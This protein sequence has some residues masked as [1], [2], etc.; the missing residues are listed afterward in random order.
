MAAD[1]SERESKLFLPFDSVDDFVKELGDNQDEL[2]FFVKSKSSLGVGK[3]VSIVA[4]V[5][6]TKSLVFLE[7]TVLWQ[8]HRS[9]GPKLPSG[10][11]VGLVDRD[12]ARL[13]SILKY[14]KTEGK[15]EQRTSPRYPISLPSAYY[16]SQGAFSSHVKNLSVGGAFIKCDGPLFTVGT[17]S[18]L[19]IYLK[20][21]RVKG[22]TV[23]TQVAWLDYFDE[24]KG[25]GLAFIAKQPQ[26][27][28]IKFLV[29][30]YERE[31]KKEKPKTKSIK[32]T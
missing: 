29:E 16:T 18:P 7:G 15:I 19:Q 1:S 32:L 30:K 5:M 27:E 17:R 22:L 26:L 20:G 8:R 13:D 12:K 24:T 14:L 28:T 4:S 3:R 9:G 23:E 11:F 31:L 6:G 25:M 2:G 10:I 21:E